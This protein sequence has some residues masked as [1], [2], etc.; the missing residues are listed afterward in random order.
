MP[1]TSVKTLV[2]TAIVTVSAA[3][4][5]VP[6]R[7]PVVPP[8]VVARVTGAVVGTWQGRLDTAIEDDLTIVFA[9]AGVVTATSPKHDATGWW[10]VTGDGTFSVDLSAAASPVGAATAGQP[11]TEPLRPERN[12]DAHHDRRPKHEENDLTQQLH[13]LSISTRQGL[14]STRLPVDHARCI[15]SPARGSPA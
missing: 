2:V 9:P 5:T 14:P 4:T 7:P 13:S 15:L 12:Q 8:D 1:Q 3:C 11:A 6:Y 10:R